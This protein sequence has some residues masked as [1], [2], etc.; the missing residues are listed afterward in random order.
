MQSN[1][2]AN[3]YTDKKSIPKSMQEF[4]EIFI[5][6]LPKHF[7]NLKISEREIDKDKKIDPI[8]VPIQNVNDIQNMM[9]EVLLN[10][11][12]L[13]AQNYTEQAFQ[14]FLAKDQIDSGVKKFFNGWNE[15]HKTTSLVSAKIIMRL[16]A[17]AVLIKDEKLNDYLVSMANMYEVAKDDFGLGHKGHD[18]MY[19]HLTSTFDSSDWVENQYKIQ[20]CN[21]FSQFLYDTGVKNNK[22]PLNSPEHA[23]SILSA[24]MVS[25]ASEI[26]NGREYN[27]LA[28][29]IENKI[30]SY[31]PEINANLNDFRN[32]KGYV[33]GHAGDIENKHGLHAFVAA[34]AFAKTKNISM[35]LN[36]LKTVMLDYNYRV[37]LAFKAIFEALK[38]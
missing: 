6:K 30:L 32:A 7:A 36:K 24:M 37:G 18:G 21:D 26:W 12:T 33:L 2:K 28:Q 22:S 13:T 1:L 17:D 4:G 14:A 11:I 9:S 19:V 5:E 34:I 15:T 20:T 10:P 25:I 35:D 38:A 3:L 31:K 23:D 8:I 27:Y 29:F 16:A